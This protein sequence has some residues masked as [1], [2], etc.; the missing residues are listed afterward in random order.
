MFLCNKMPK[1]PCVPNRIR[2]S[3]N[4]NINNRYR[5][6]KRQNQTRAIINRFRI[7]KKK[8]SNYRKNCCNSDSRNPHFRSIKTSFRPKQRRTFDK[9]TFNSVRISIKRQQT[10][11]IHSKIIRPNRRKYPAQ[12]KQNR[13][14]NANKNYFTLRRHLSNNAHLHVIYRFHFKPTY[15]YIYTK[16]MSKINKSRK[17]RLF[18]L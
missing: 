14:N 7:T 2:K 13:N 10:K 17:N 4:Y 6:I 11:K 8:R 9:N 15:T 16:I 18:I 1:R 5:N 12:K 3:T